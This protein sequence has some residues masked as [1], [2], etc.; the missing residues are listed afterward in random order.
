M[1]GGIVSRNQT[2]QPVSLYNALPPTS[3]LAWEPQCKLFD[4]LMCVSEI[5]SKSDEMPWY[6]LKFKWDEGLSSDF[7]FSSTDIIKNTAQFEE[8]ITKREQ[9][10][11]VKMKCS[12]RRYVAL[13]LRIDDATEEQRFKDLLFR[14]RE[15]YEMIDE[16]TGEV[17]QDSL[18]DTDILSSS[19]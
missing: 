3:S 4:G 10:Y 6:Q 7:L 11:K 18:Q 12:K 14:I 19:W 2:F 17:E 15:E 13:E 16:L 8:T 9:W 1:S 5:L